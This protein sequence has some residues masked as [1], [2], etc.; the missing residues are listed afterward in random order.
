MIYSNTTYR[1]SFYQSKSSNKASLR[2]IDSTSLLESLLELSDPVLIESSNRK[3]VFLTPNSLDMDSISLDTDVVDVT[4]LNS[5]PTFRPDKKSKKPDND[6][7]LETSKTKNKVKKRSRSRVDFD[8]E[9][10]IVHEDDSKE[11]LIHDVISLSVERPLK[12]KFNVENRLNALNKQKSQNNQKKGKSIQSKTRKVVAR[13]DL[14]KPE[15]VSLRQPL[16]IQELATLFCATDTEIIKILFLQGI[17]VTTNQVIDVETATVVGQHLGIE[18]EHLFDREDNKRKQFTSLDKVSSER[19]PPIISILGHVDHGKTSLLDKIRKTQI[20][21]TE[22]GGIT[23]RL[24]AYDVEV[25]YKTEIRTLVFL[26]TPGH[27]AFS[28]MRFRGIQVTDIALL[29]VAA[30]D[31][32]QPQ[33]IEAIEYIQSFKIP[34][35]IVIN[36]IDKEDARIEGIKQELSK[37]NL[38]SE[39]WGGETPMISISAKQGTNV[40][41]LL[42]VIL[43]LTDA[44]N[45]TTDPNGLVRGTVLEAQVDRTKGP[46]ASVLIHSGT[47]RVGDTLVVGELVTKVRG[48]MNSRGEKV[49]SALPSF[50]VLVWG[51]SKAPNAGQIFEAYK[52]DKDARL[53]SQNKPLTQRSLAN[54]QRG[55]ESYSALTAET[56]VKI[57][58]I[59]KADTQGSAEAI[60][61]TIHKMSYTKV[62]VRILYAS[63]G[64]ITET[65]VNFAYTSASVMLAFNTT[66]APGARK[67]AR[68]RNVTI[69][70]VN[71]IYDLLDYVEK[72]IESL[73]GPEY[74]EQLIGT[75]VVKSIFPLG[76]SFVAGS[77]VSMGRLAQGCHI[78][79]IRGETSI[80]EGVL[81]S[82]KRLKDDVNEVTK[83]SDCGV[84]LKGFDTWVEKDVIKAFNLVPKKNS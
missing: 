37:Y 18:V 41:N 60:V 81:D 35:I 19:R 57:N 23:Q 75:A 15:M 44:A 22:F 52:E 17:S 69:K 1:S 38:I 84:F 31:G 45:F 77:F 20:A 63:A 26:D 76:K 11:G 14:T 83:D 47:L 32:I 65:D 40:D 78:K 43:S 53:V 12:P 64:E 46:I 49:P 39:S 74:E 9:Y 82:L 29:V 24:G 61:N 42:D 34:V 27:E 5:K 68:S 6:D 67:S 79:V 28:E 50:P 3:R 30:D 59:I 58:L 36:K 54:L 10:E 72:M 21:Q 13:K 51:F 66:L 55:V 8:D 25:E 48:I 56:K 62:D 80:Y 71:V 2:A 4:A 16:G 7:D 70:E 73:I 33:T